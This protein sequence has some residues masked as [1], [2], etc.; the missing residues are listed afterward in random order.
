L[1][2]SGALKLEDIFRWT[3]SDRHIASDVF[4]ALAVLYVFSVTFIK[5]SI[6]FFYRRTFTMH[7]VWFKLAWWATMNLIFLWAATCITLIALQNTGTL[8]KAGFSRI[9]ISTTGIVNGLSDV[10][11]MILPAVMISKMRL[12]KKQKI[13]IMGI[14]MIGGV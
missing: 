10:I 9:G 7:E 12:P 4:C 5:L 11:L 6:L 8:P 2:A 1:T 3:V 14:F 13:A